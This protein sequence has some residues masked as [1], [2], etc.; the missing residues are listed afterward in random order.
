MVTG[1]RVAED[2]LRGPMTEAGWQSRAA[3]WFSRSL[4]PDHLGVVAV[5]VASK[6]ASAGAAD[7]TA[8]VGLRVEAVEAVVSNICESKRTDYRERTAVTGLGYLMPENRWREW[9]ID[10]ESATSVAIELCNAIESSGLP[11]LRTLATDA[12]ELLAQIKASPGFDQA[13]GLT[14]YA[15]I[16]A[17][18][19]RVD[20]AMGSVNERSAAL[21][22]RSDPAAEVTRRAIDRLRGWLVS[23]V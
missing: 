1:R 7:V 19:G 15:V 5:G 9:P 12:D 22:G 14:R 18:A 23:P 10:A 11:W 6:Y 20:D 4:G 21:E 16:L 13:T 2:A 3:G 17:Q 8:Y